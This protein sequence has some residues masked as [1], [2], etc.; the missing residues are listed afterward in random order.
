MWTMITNGTANLIRPIYFADHELN[1]DVEIST[2]SAHVQLVAIYSHFNNIFLGYKMFHSF[3]YLQV[4]VFMFKLL[5]PKLLH[6]CI[7]DAGI[8]IRPHQFSLL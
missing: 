6:L 5:R 3:L 1:V 8:T 2:N 7:T 4:I